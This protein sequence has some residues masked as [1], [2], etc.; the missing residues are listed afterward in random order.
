[1]AFSVR[2]T[3]TGICLFVP[4]SRADARAKMCVVLPDGRGV[5]D[6]GDGTVALQASASTI[7]S[8]QPL[9]RHMAFMTLQARDLVGGGGLSER[10]L[11]LCYLEGHRVVLRARGGSSTMTS[12]LRTIADLSQAIPQYRFDPMIVSAN[13]R[14]AVAQILIDRGTLQGGTP[15]DSWVFPN[16]ISQGE[17]VSGP[18]SHEVHLDLRDLD[19]FA[20][21]AQPFSGGP[22]VVWEFAP[23]NGSGVAI[24]IANL[25]DDNPLRWPIPRPRPLPDEDFQ[26]YYEM[27][28]QGEKERLATNVKGLPLPIPHPAQGSGNGQGINC[29]PGRTAPIDYNLDVFLPQP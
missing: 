6:R 10:L 14:T 29:V 9:R 1:M 20:L 21:V 24:T 19:S 5:V 15:L 23:P 17:P 22:D 11:G 16:T 12:D 25:C 2:I 3:F 27:L 28:E 18:L 26:W 13:P 4:N 8:S 7:V